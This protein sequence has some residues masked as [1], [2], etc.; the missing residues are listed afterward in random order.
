M[1]PY[2]NVGEIDNCSIDNFEIYLNYTGS[3]KYL[4]Y[5]KIHLSFV[6]VP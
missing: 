6:Y 1:L 5:P 2:K 4:L 3:K